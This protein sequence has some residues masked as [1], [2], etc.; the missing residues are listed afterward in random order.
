[1]NTEEVRGDRTRCGKCRM[2]RLI[3]YEMIENSEKIYICKTCYN[4]FVKSQSKT[5]KCL[6]CEKEFSS[7]NDSR[8]CPKCQQRLR[9]NNKTEY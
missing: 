1:M 7:K 9:Y 3:N 5:R 8:T 2:K 4:D 6:R